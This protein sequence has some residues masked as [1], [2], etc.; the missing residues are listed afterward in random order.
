[1][2]AVKLLASTYLKLSGIFWARAQTVVLLTYLDFEEIALV[3]G[4]TV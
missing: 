2:V 4:V 1:M 3:A